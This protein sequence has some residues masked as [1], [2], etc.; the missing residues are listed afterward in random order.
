MA[1]VRKANPTASRIRG[2]VAA[3]RDQT[4]IVGLTHNF[5][6]HP[7]RFSPSFVAAAIQCFSR[8]GDLVLDPFV[9]GGTTIIEAMISGR[10]AV[11]SDLNSLSIFVTRVKTSILSRA[12]RDA[13]GTTRRRLR[14]TR[15]TTRASRTRSRKSRAWSSQSLGS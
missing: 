1:A 9:G 15:S 11:G 3:A 14:T 4:P 5:Y 13:I 10:R 2:F 7:A 8:P 6:R 12:E